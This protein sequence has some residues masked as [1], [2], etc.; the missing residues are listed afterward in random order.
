[1]SP[2]R[3]LL[4]SA[5]VLAL[6]ACSGDS[7]DG[8]VA[9]DTST[10]DTSAPPAVETTPT[11]APP[12][13]AADTVVLSVNGVE[14]TE[15]E[16][17]EELTSAAE[18]AET[19]PGQADFLLPDAAG[20]ATVEAARQILQQRVETVLADEALAARG[21]AVTDADTE[22]VEGLIGEVTITPWLEL[23]VDRSVRSVALQRVIQEEAGIAATAEEW[24]A[25]NAAELGFACS[26]HIL[27]DTVDDAD[28][29][30]ARI[31]DD[32]DDFAT[33]AM[34]LSTGPSGPTGGDLGCGDPAQFV[35]EFAD[36]VRTLPIAEVSEPVQTEFGFHVIEV[37]SRGAEVGFEQIADAASQAW[38]LEISAAVSGPL[39]ELTASADVTVDPAYGTWDGTRIA[40]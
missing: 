31:V 36:A 35:P 2:R 29:A 34:E 6:A 27:L 7:D 21:G 12:D 25:D 19:N 5:L 3:F 39:T 24:Y 28:A 16:L 26:R 33:V 40:P 20:N 4:F 11:S 30:R 8:E 23:F 22:L 18:F 9:T 37:T 10:A 14:T 38:Q 1:M 17:R 32:G 13:L 15:G